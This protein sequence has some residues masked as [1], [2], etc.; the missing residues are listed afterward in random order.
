MGSRP[1]C[2][3]SVQA[4][5]TAVALSAALIVRISYPLTSVHGLG[6]RGLG[7]KVQGLGLRSP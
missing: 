4:L 3:E 1:N 2:I 5:A 6:L 7:F